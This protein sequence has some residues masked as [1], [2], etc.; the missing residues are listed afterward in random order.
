LIP[1]LTLVY[2]QTVPRKE[3]RYM[4]GA[5]PFFTILIAFA[6]VH[7]YEYIKKHPKPLI[8]PKAFII[9][10]AILV[11][12]YIPTT[13]NF[14]FSPDFTQE[15]KQ[16]IKENNITG[17]ILSSDPAFVSFVENN[18]ILFSGAEYASVIYNVSKGKYELMFVDSCD[19]ACEINDNVCTARIE[20]LHQDIK[21]E[22][23]E[24]YSKTYTYKKRKCTYKIYLPKVNEK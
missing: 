2:F 4:V 21:K 19:F 22:N 14:E 8:R 3:V 16:I 24:V 17:P 13:I 10:I 5:V 1:T 12:S 9:L 6:L 18:L 15:V 7:L 23:N 11:I 20:K